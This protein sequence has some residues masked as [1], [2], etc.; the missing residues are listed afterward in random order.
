MEQKEKKVL[1]MLTM[2]VAAA[3]GKEAAKSKL[4][5]SGPSYP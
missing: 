5:F 1:A 2:L 4:V 3:H